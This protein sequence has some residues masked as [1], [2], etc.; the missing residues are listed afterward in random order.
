MD[1]A[2]V[3]AYI[4]VTTQLP[5][6]PLQPPPPPQLPPLLQ[7]SPESVVTRHQSRPPSPL[8]S[9]APSPA[10]TWKP[11]WQPARPPTPYHEPASPPNTPLP[12]YSPHRDITYQHGASADLHQSSSAP[13][14]A[15]LAQWR[16]AQSE[17]AARPIVPTPWT[18]FKWGTTEDTNQEPEPWGHS[19]R[20]SSDSSLPRAATLT[21]PLPLILT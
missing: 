12:T 5:A 13:A 1:T 20:A 21:L 6:P 7:L 8:L 4:R 9:L 2:A 10:F 15:P 17:E 3:D 11:S 19:R 16:Q 14:P 18:V